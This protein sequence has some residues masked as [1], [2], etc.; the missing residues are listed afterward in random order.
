MHTNN[1][2]EIR[3]F[4]TDCQYRWFVCLH[5]TSTHLGLQKPLW[6]E[7]QPRWKSIHYLDTHMLSSQ[8]YARLVV[9]REGSPGYKT[10]SFISSTCL[11]SCELLSLLMV[12]PENHLR[13]E[14]HLELGFHIENV[15]PLLE[16][17]QLLLSFP[18]LNCRLECLTFYHRTNMN[19]LSRILSPYYSMT[20]LTLWHPQ[21]TVWPPE[22]ASSRNPLR[23]LN[24]THITLLDRIASVLWLNIFP[25]FLCAE[26]SLVYPWGSFPWYNCAG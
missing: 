25:S 21:W 18:Q 20:L 3:F 9:S 7:K 1:C 5:C 14:L 24:K 22:A 17:S 6:H 11:H 26:L 23:Q 10:M 16:R 13:Q 8:P 12:L 19:W 15:P 2:F 4:L